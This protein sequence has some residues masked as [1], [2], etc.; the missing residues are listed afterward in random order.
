MAEKL[1]AERRW[2]M[3]ASGI[4][5]LVCRDIEERQRR[6]IAKYGK[7][8]AANPL[9]L[10]EW[11]THAYEEALDFAIYLRRAMEECRV[12]EAAG[13][14]SP[15]IAAGLPEMAKRYGFALAMHCGVLRWSFICLS[16][17]TTEK[18]TDDD[19]FTSF[20]DEACLRWNLQARPE[21]RT[22]CLH[23]IVWLHSGDMYLIELSLVR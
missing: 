5:E 12:P 20:V 6:G 3:A 19:R 13:N 10:R 17:V 9:V 15:V 2:L 16:T 4:E 21:V 11:L 7:T 1:H 18:A 8:V 23:K 14:L 22:D